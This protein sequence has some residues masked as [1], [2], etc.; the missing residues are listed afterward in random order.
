MRFLPDPFNQHD[1][2]DS[3]FLGVPQA[4]MTWAPGA[5]CLVQ[6]PRLRISGVSLKT[7]VL[8]AS[9][10]FHSLDVGVMWDA[11]RCAMVHIDLLLS[12]YFCGG[13]GNDTYWLHD[14]ARW[15]S[16]DLNA[17][18]YPTATGTPVLFRVPLTY[19]QNRLRK[20]T[21][22]EVFMGVFFIFLTFGFCWLSA[23]GF[24]W[25]WLLVVAVVVSGCENRR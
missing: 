21:Q 9:W 16:L 14:H 23:F 17:S 8:V 22:K 10:T 15:I 13:C 11:V 18:S 12:T 20:K 3:W 5:R 6:L 7:G 1:I 24:S 19:F 25:L 2:F 4:L